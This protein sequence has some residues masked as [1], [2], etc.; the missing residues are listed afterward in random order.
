MEGASLDKPDNAWVTE[1]VFSQ[2]L[3]IFDLQ[4]LVLDYFF[5]VNLEHLGDG[6][7]SDEHFERKEISKFLVFH[8]LELFLVALASKGKDCILR[9]LV[10][11]DN[12]L[13]GHVELTEV[14]NGVDFTQT[15]KVLYKVQ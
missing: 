15:T 7:F 8:F 11:G 5:I 13:V 12:I 10:S 2:F 4:E 1:A 14:E 3:C 6:H 9:Q